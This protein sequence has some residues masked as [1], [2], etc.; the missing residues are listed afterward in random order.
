MRARGAGPV[1]S[2]FA[3]STIVSIFAVFTRF[4][5]FTA[6]S[7]FTA[8]SAFAVFTVPGISGCFPI[9]IRFARIRRPAPGAA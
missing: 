2:V 9:F 8:L 1:R 6:L 5:V 3:V 4:G 7:R